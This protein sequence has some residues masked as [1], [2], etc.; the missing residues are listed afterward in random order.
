MNNTLLPSS[1]CENNNT[2][3]SLSFLPVTFEE[4]AGVLIMLVIFIIL[5]MLPPSIVTPFLNQRN[6]KRI[7]RMVEQKRNHASV[8]NNQE[9]DIELAYYSDREEV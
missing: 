9:N 3:T 4:A 6:Y 5:S 1:Q 2:I 7:K 8:P